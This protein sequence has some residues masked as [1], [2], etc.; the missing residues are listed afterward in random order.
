MKPNKLTRHLK[1]K[2]SETGKNVENFNRR[3]DEIRIQQNSSVNL[4]TV[5]C[6]TLLASQQVSYTTAQNK[7]THTIPD[8]VILP[9]ATDTAHRARSSQPCVQPQ[10]WRTRSLYLCPPVTGWPSHTPNHRVPFSSFYDSLGYGGDILTR[11]HMGRSAIYR[12]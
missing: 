10:T 2:H 11:L 1:T 5:S 4:T 6:R 12:Y 7:K 3:L 9:A 8:T